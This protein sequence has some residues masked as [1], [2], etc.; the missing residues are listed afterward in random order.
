MIKKIKI[1]NQKI[2]E[3]L[4]LN[5]Q[6]KFIDEV[7][8]YNKVS[9]ALKDREYFKDTSITIREFFIRGFNFSFSHDGIK[10]WHEI[11]EKYSNININSEMF[12]IY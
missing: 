4:P 11:I 8:H 12:P 5:I 9:F 7:N 2:L 3:S 10:Y 6:A 1:S